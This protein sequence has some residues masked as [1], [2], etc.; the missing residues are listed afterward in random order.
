LTLEIA[1]LPPTDFSA[2]TS[3]E[4]SNDTNDS[5]NKEKFFPGVFLAAT[6][7]RFVRPVKNLEC[8]GIEFIGPLE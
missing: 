2:A 4:D 7:S 1:Y 5:D 8:G 3:N 6:P